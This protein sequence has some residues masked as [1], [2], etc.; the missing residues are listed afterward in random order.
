MRVN[1]KKWYMYGEWQTKTTRALPNKVWIPGVNKKKQA[2]THLAGINNAKI[3]LQEEAAGQKLKRSP[4]SQ[5]QVSK[6]E[7]R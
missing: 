1:V 3:G 4:G 7:D 2:D 6:K 5:S